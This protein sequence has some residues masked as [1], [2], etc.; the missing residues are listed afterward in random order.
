MQSN[1]GSNGLEL[2][3]LSYGSDQVLNTNEPPK[4]IVVVL[5]VFVQLPYFHTSISL[6]LERDTDR[7]TGFILDRLGTMRRLICT[8]KGSIPLLG[9]TVPLERKLISISQIPVSAPGSPAKF[10]FSVPFPEIVSKESVIWQAAD[11]ESLLCSSTETFECIGGVVLINHVC[12]KRDKVENLI[13]AFG[14][15]GKLSP[16]WTTLM[17]VDANDVTDPSVKEGYGTVN[18]LN[19]RDYERADFFLDDCKHTI[20]VD[21]HYGPTDNCHVI[22][23]EETLGHLYRDHSSTAEAS[24]EGA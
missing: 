11:S 12:P 21:I 13:L 22:H 10:R 5:D 23:V 9:I 15:R 8:E 3:L 20:C 7:D 18:L 4:K 24:S 2:Q 6:V 19:S 17:E 14:T 16:V 1:F